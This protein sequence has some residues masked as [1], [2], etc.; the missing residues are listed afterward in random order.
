MVN[1]SNIKNKDTNIMVNAGS[2]KDLFYKHALL[3][4][5]LV[6]TSLVYLE[7]VNFQF[8]YDDVLQIKENQHLR[9]WDHIPQYFTD[10]TWSHIYQVG[11]YYRPIFLL[12]LLINYSLFGQNPMGWHITTIL[13]HLVA[14]LLVYVLINRISRDRILAGIATL[15]FAL[16]P[17]HI[18]SVAWISGV[19]DPL[20]LVFL[21]S[22]FL[23]YLN[24]HNA[25]NNRSRFWLILSLFLYAIGLLEKETAIIFPI[26][27][28]A[29]V[30]MFEIRIEE[31]ESLRDRIKKWQIGILRIAPYLLISCIYLV[32]RVIVLKGLSHKAVQLSTMTTVCTWPSIFWGHFKLLVWPVK[33][34][35]FYD[36]SYVN[37][38][39]SL[40]FILP[41]IGV[42]II[43]SCLYWWSRYNKLVGFASIWLI[44]PLLPLLAISGMLENEFL[45]D[46][47]LYIPS[48]GFAI[49]IALALRHINI[50]ERKILELP[51]IQTICL[52]V[53][54]CSLSLGILH[55]IP[56]WANNL[57][58]FY[59]GLKIAPNNYLVA[60][61]LAK[62]LGDRGMYAEAISICRQV[63]ARKPD[64]AEANQN[65]GYYSYRIGQYKEAEYYL[66]QAIKLNPNSPKSLRILGLTWLEMG[67][68]DQAEEALRHAISIRQRQPYGYHFVLGIILKEKGDLQGALTEFKMELDANPE[69]KNAEGEVKGLIARLH[70]K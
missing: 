34:S 19:T 66:S 41:F 36:S 3:I 45:H 24:R 27:I 35:A 10:H 67:M 33:L 2:V 38:F 29:Y 49:I 15:I 51:A 43:A 56:H 52:I 39:N 48:V 64:F 62:E 18:E 5:A 68:L 57:T 6:L 44:S 21:A 31:R 54:T 60:N 28:F 42:I 58:L 11:N 47:Y 32:V 30:I 61:N 20:L 40:K 8:V 17:T 23:C 1:E 50:A 65:L 70:N 16:H 37:N 22:S 7:T 63:L 13:V 53:L 59:H 46:R 26:I 14:V 4:T 55:Q 69:D 9:S 25:I 12:W